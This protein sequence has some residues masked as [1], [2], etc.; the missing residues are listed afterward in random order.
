LYLT[1]FDNLIADIPSATLPDDKIIVDK[2]PAISEF[3]ELD[4]AYKNNINT[5]TIIVFFCECRNIIPEN[6]ITY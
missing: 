5:G 3:K 1:W 6:E 4:R 2:Q